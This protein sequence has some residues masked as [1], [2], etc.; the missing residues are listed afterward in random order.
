MCGMHACL[1][2]QSRFDANSDLYA[3]RKQFHQAALAYYV[4]LNSVEYMKQ[5]V[6]LQSML[7]FMHCQVGG[8][9]YYFNC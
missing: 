9:I 1:F 7:S 8:A 4:D 2:L 6:L 3:A 5:C